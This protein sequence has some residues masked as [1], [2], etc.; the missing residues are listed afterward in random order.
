MAILFS[1]GQ[2]VMQTGFNLWLS[3][4]FLTRGEYFKVWLTRAPGEVSGFG[5]LSG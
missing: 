5:P 2:M 1:A 3:S 4:L